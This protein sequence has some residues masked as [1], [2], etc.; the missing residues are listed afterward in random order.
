VCG[1]VDNCPSEANADQA[2][3]NEN[4]VGDACDP[5]LP[6]VPALPPWGLGVLSA[7]LLVIGARRVG[8]TR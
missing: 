1:D 4:G 6:R 3:W 7:L 5:E 8:K 2:D